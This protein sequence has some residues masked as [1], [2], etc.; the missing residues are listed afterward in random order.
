MVAI[1]QVPV[2]HNEPVHEYAAGSPE[3]SRLAGSLNSLA[4]DPIELP[5]VIGGKH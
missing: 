5:H 3:R 4:N 2:P 1:T